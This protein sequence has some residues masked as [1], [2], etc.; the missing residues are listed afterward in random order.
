[1]P[2]LDMG[3]YLTEKA[4]LPFVPPLAGGLT[5][6]RPG[7]VPMTVALLHGYIR[8]AGSGWDYTMDLLGRYYEQ[9]L[10]YTEVP[11]ALDMTIQRLRALTDEGPPEEAGG[12]VGTFLVPAENLGQRTPPLPLALA[13]GTSDAAFAPDRMT[14]ADLSALAADLCRHAEQVLEVLTS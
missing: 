3:R 6:R 4:A 14:A 9:A 2:E 5:Y 11:L 13:Q 7:A 12:A 1:H 8:S 10:G